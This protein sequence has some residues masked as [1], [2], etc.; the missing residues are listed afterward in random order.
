MRALPDILL[1]LA[2]EPDLRELWHY[3]NAAGL[4]RIDFQPQ[5]LDWYPAELPD[6]CIYENGTLIVAANTHAVIDYTRSVAAGAQP[7]SVTSTLTIR[8]GQGAR[9]DLLDCAQVTGTGEPVLHLQTLNADIGR[10]AT[11][12][13]VRLNDLPTGDYL[14]TRAEIMVAASGHYNYTARSIGAVQ[15]R[16][17]LNV[18][19]AGDGASAAFAGATQLA[20]RQA[21]DHTIIVEHAARHTSSTQ[22]FRAVVDGEARAAFQGKIVVAEGAIKTDAR[23]LHKGLIL[24]PRGTVDAKPELEILNDDVACSHGSTCGAL[25]ED[26]LFYLRARGLPE[27]VARRLLIAAFVAEALQDAPVFKELLDA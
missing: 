16:H 26:A 12:N 3:T 10:D 1:P 21:S 17:Q 7:L 24:S 23:Q 5:A 20:G 14:F 4:A 22:N 19:L 11:L 8:L 2:P 13:H 27:D 9:L 25:D 15:S 6:G 18:K